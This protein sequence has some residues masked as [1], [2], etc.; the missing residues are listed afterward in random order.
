MKNRYGMA[1]WY[2]GRKVKSPARH[3]SFF[4]TSGPIMVVL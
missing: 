2:H 3:S 1:M 4:M